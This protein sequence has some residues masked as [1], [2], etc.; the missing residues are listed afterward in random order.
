MCAEVYLSNVTRPHALPSLGL[1][2]SFL[3]SGIVGQTGLDRVCLVFF[4]CSL[5]HFSTA[6]HMPLQR[7][8]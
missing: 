6:L 3:S 1:P 7:R 2:F 5:L 8:D 4:L